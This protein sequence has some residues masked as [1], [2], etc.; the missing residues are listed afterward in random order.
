MHYKSGLTDIQRKASNNL[1]KLWMISLYWRIE[2]SSSIQLY[3]REIL[4]LLSSETTTTQ[5]VW[6]LMIARHC[7]HYQQV[8]WRLVTV[9]WIKINCHCQYVQPPVS[10]NHSTV[11]GL[12]DQWERSVATCPAK[13]KVGV[14]SLSLL[15]AVWGFPPPSALPPP[16]HNDVENVSA[17]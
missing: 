14:K 1:N 8:M 7:S 15:W 16:L 2:V 3:R 6:K 5:T 12:S 4:F 17:L 10:T 13:R 9:L 11:A